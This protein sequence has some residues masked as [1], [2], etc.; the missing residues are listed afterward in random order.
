M[1]GGDIPDHG[2][3]SVAA[4]D[5]RQ[6]A[7]PLLDGLLLDQLRG[8]G[9]LEKLLRLGLSLCLRDLALPRPWPL[10][11]VPGLLAA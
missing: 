6:V 10:G 8:E 1:A 4:D 9:L 2:E 3:D 7:V 11:V 5:R